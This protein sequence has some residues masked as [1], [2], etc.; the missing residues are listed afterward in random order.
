MLHAQKEHHYQYD[1]AKA[2]SYLATTLSWIGD[3]AAEAPAREVI[4]ALHPGVE[5]RT[6]P[7]RIV[8]AHLD[9][10]LTLLSLDRLDEA[11]DAAQNAVLS[12]RLLPAN[13]WRVLEIV[14][15]VEARKLPEAPE[16]REAYQDL[17]PAIGY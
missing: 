1:P 10:A 6:W 15:S 11:C 17:N 3:P 16:L 9:L 7:R 14:R 4:G 8:T 2:T 5:P 12:E 13:H